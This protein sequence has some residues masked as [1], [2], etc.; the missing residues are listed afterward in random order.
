MLEISNLVHTLGSTSS[1]SVLG[2]ICRVHRLHFG[3]KPGTPASSSQKLRI[4]WLHEAKR[5]R[6][7]GFMKPNTPVHL[8][9][10]SQT[11]RSIWLHEAKCS[12]AFGF[13][14]PKAPEV[15]SILLHKAKCSRAFGLMKPNVLEHWPH[16]AKWSGAFGFMKLGT[17]ASRSRCTQLHA[18]WSW[19]TQ[20]HEVFKFYSCICG[21]IGRTYLG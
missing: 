4:V 13:M 11:I 18:K 5:S 12:G 1:Y 14:K 17:P 9:S 20:L 10:W 6:T 7:F 16:E 8:A 2:N 3:M 15:Q 19:C 21:R